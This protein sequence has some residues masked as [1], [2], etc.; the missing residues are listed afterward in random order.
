MF[1]SQRWQASPALM[2]SL[3]MVA[4]A[5]APIVAH[6]PAIASET[7]IA[8]SLFNDARVTIPEGTQIAVRYDE[9][10]EDGEVADKIIVAPGETVSVTLT[11]AES[12]RS[13]RG[14]VLLPEGSK[15]EGE[16]RPLGD[17][18]VGTRFYAEELILPNGN[19]YEIDATS[20][21][22]TETEI[23]TE[24]SDRDFLKGAVIGAAAAA[25]LAEILGSIDVLEVLGGAGLGA[26]GILIFGGRDEEV[27]VVVVE[28]NT[29]LN[30]TVQSDFQL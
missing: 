19:R 29:D 7:L 10:T 23:I 12:L 21:A 15:V 30:L 26:L 2:L 8:Q 27:E 28:P 11:V 5:A 1:I 22:V 25:V 3:G 9:E 14:T 17:D 13:S 16:L 24:E 20:A 18:Q 4:A 6:A